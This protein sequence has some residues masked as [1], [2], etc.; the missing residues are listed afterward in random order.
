MFTL[1]TSAR[2]KILRAVQLHDNPP[3]ISAETDAFIPLFNY[4]SDFE[5]ERWAVQQ[6]WSSCKWAAPKDESLAAAMMMYYGWGQVYRDRKIPSCCIYQ[7][8]RAEDG[9]HLIISEP[10]TFNDRLTAACARA[11]SV[12]TS[13]HKKNRTAPFNLL[14]QEAARVF[15]SFNHYFVSITP[16]YRMAIM[17]KLQAFCLHLTN[18][19]DTVPPQFPYIDQP[20]EM[21]QVEYNEYD[22]P[23]EYILK[24]EDFI[25]ERE[26]SNAMREQRVANNVAAHHA[27]F[28]AVLAK[29]PD[30]TREYTGAELRQYTSSHT[31]TKG[32][33]EGNIILTRKVGRTPYYRLNYERS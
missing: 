1:G 11:L 25:I 28:E 32:I 19:L 22:E 12:T 33:K 20:E 18:A 10:H 8:R 27:A 7:M 24:W 4:L 6:Q 13:L 3:P 31:I 2:Y 26:S 5:P 23:R 15:F 14:F 16:D 29:L 17:N 9:I 30:P 21:F